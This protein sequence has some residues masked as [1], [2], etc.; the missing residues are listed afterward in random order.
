MCIRDRS[1]DEPYEVGRRAAED[2]GRAK[3]QDVEDVV[4]L[5]RHLN[6]EGFEP[7]R[8]GSD[9]VLH[10]CPFADIAAEGPSVVCEIHR[11][12]IDGYLPTPAKLVARNP[13]EARCEIRIAS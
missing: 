7:E 5:M 11:G 3:P 10:A 6:V 12:L 8:D 4:R 2:A 9:I 1:G 13:H